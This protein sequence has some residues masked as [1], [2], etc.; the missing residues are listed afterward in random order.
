MTYPK[1]KSWSFVTY[2]NKHNEVAGNENK[3]GINWIEMKLESNGMPWHKTCKA[4]DHKLEHNLAS[5]LRLTWDEHEDKVTWCWNWNLKDH[6]LKTAWFQLTKYKLMR[7]NDIPQT[8][9]KVNRWKWNQTS[10][11]C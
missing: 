8:E 11:N 5:N 9:I 3:A 2:K 6:E 4:I 7:W 1:L 10:W